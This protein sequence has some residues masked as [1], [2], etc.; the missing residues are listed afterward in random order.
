MKA[1]NPRKTYKDV[2][3]KP[4]SRSVSPTLE[5]FVIIQENGSSGTTKVSFLINVCDCEKKG[6]ICNCV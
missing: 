5:G 3:H 1:S 2:E 4:G 6:D